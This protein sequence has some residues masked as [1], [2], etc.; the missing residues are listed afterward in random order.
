MPILDRINWLAAFYVL[1]SVAFPGGTG[2]SRTSGLHWLLE[3]P[4][5]TPH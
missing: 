2:I 4:L 5:S 1:V 3:A